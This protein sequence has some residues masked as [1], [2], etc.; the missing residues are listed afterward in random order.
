VR[1]DRASAA[2]RGWRTRA[3]ATLWRRFNR[4]W[5]DRMHDANP[6][7]RRLSFAI[8]SA[9]IVLAALS[10]WLPHPWNFSPLEAMAL[11]AGARIADRRLAMLV[12]LLALFLSDW[13]IGFYADIWVVYACFAAMALAGRRLRQA[14]PGKIA[15]YGLISA[16]GFF[17]I[18]NFS[19]WALGT[20]Y[21]HTAS[22]LIGAYV[23]ALPFLQNQLAGVA[24]YGVLLFGG[25]ALLDHG[26]RASEKSPLGY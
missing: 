1:D 2:D 22:G 13:F 15:S 3:P 16:G 19:V 17:L 8:V 11:F 4:H 18:T 20:M 25:Y 9:M 23:S 14:G 24:F 10:R 21:P 5:N 6:T 26:L 7:D 12:P